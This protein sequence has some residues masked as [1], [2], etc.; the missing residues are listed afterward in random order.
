MNLYIKDK[1]LNETNNDMV[2]LANEKAIIFAK[3]D[4][5]I[6]GDKDKINKTEEIVNKSA[7]IQTKD[8]NIDI[9]ANILTNKRA[10]DYTNDAFV[11][12]SKVTDSI[13]FQEGKSYPSSG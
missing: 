12:T 9:Y 8:G 13:Y 3:N 4:M 1:L 10:L 11:A 7:D 5:N 6:Q 2:D